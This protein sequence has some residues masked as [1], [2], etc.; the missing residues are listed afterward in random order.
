LQAQLSPSLSYAPPAKDSGRWI[1]VMAAGVLTTALTL[2][3]TAWLANQSGGHVNLLGIYIDGIL[4][5]GALIL[6]A[7]A[8]SGYAVGAWLLGCR[9][10]RPLLLGICGLTLLAYGLTQYLEFRAL[11]P[12]IHR[13]TGQPVTFLEH[14]DSATRAIHFVST[15]SPFNRQH[16]EAAEGLGWLGY[17]VR[18]L[19]AGAF[20]TGA[21]LTPFLA[22]R[23]KKFCDLC[24]QYYATLCLGLLPASVPPKKTLGF[25]TPSSVTLDG[26]HAVAGR[27]AQQLVEQMASCLQNGE[28]EEFTR[29]LADLQAGSAAAKKL[30]RRAE[31]LLSWCKSCGN[32]FFHSNMVTGLDGRK[33]RTREII[34]VPVEAAVAAEI[35]ANRSEPLSRREGE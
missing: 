19:E 13:S 21:I 6:G 23:K 9:I 4:P 24:E 12:L 5:I 30:P 18:A 29:L 10:G 15:Y 3:G 28:I 11:G 35:R 20:A 1:Y 32:A 26:E 25:L 8:A 7:C 33:A 22:L 2:A 16:E 31:L 27:Q 34:A 17:G 14:F